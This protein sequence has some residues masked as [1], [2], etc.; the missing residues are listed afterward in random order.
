MIAYRIL[1][2]RRHGGRDLAKDKTVCLELTQL[3]SEHLFA[4]TPD[5]TTQGGE[6]ERPL[7]EA[8]HDRGLPFSSDDGGGE[9]DIGEIYVPAAWMVFHALTFL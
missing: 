8:T 2:L 6:P 4:D 7:H 1:H 3:L 5:G 9:L